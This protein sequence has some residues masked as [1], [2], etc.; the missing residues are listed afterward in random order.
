MCRQRKYLLRRI[1]VGCF[2]GPREK[3]K[4]RERERERERE[5]EGR[6]V[7][8]VRQNTQNRTRLCQH[9]VISEWPLDGQSFRLIRGNIGRLACPW[10]RSLSSPRV[11]TRK[12][13]RDTAQSH[14]REKGT[15]EGA[16]ASKVWKTLTFLLSL[17]SLVVYRIV[18][19]LSLFLD[20]WSR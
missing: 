6:N 17:A 2:A 16:T 7:W 10:S 1:C 19:K 13:S 5:K 9:R 8:F 4:V 11:E 12:S 14:V 20:V 3:K 18:I 15:L